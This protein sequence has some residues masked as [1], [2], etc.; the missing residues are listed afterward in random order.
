M[1]FIKNCIV[2]GGVKKPVNHHH[3][4]KSFS[5]LL[6]LLSFLLLSACGGGGDDP[7]L[8]SENTAISGFVIDGPISG[9]NVTLHRVNTDGTT[10]DQVAGPFTTDASGQW[11][12]TVP[13]NITGTL[14]VVA[15]GGQYTDDATGST[16]TLAADEVL[17]SWF[18]PANPADQGVVSPIT[19]SLWQ[20]AKQGMSTGDTLAV[21]VAAAE[22]LATDF[23][24]FDPTST[25]PNTSSTTAANLRYG[26]MLGG[27]SFLMDNR[28]ELQLEPFSSM[29]RFTLTR[30][31]M[32]DMA[33]GRLDG[34][35]IDGSRLEAPD[36]TLF[37][38]LSGND[39]SAFFTQVN[40]YTA[41]LQLPS[42]VVPNNYTV[43][44]SVYNCP[45]DGFFIYGQGTEEQNL[46]GYNN[47]FPN[48]TGFGNNVVKVA[49]RSVQV[50]RSTIT[51][52]QTG[53]EGYTDSYEVTF[54][55]PGLNLTSSNGSFLSGNV[56]RFV[57]QGYAST[58]TSTGDVRFLDVT[59]RGTY[60]W[61]GVRPDP[62]LAY[63]TSNGRL[64]FERGAG[65]TIPDNNFFNNN[66]HFASI[67]GSAEVGSGGPPIFEPAGEDH[68]DLFFVAA[69]VEGLSGTVVL[70]NNGGNTKSISTNSLHYFSAPI[71]DE[72]F[73][74]VSIV[75]QPDGQTCSLTSSAGQIAGS[76]ITS[77]G[78]SCTNNPE[79]TYSIGGSVS[80]LNGGSLVL[81]NNAGDDLPLSADGSF[82]FSTELLT[83]VGYG[84][85]ILSEPASQDCTVSNA[86]GT[87][88][89]ADITNV[90][91]SCV[92]VTTSYSI[93]GNVSGLIGTLVLRNNAGD[94]L[95]LSADGSFAFSTELLTGVGYSVTIFSSP[96]SQNCAV[97]SG[98]G[99][100]ST[101]DITTVSV[102]CAD[103]P[104]YTIGGSVTGLIGTLVLQ[105]NAGNNLTL[106]TN[107][108]F[109]FSTRLLSGVG[110][111]VTILS[112]PAAQN[113]SVTNPSGTVSNANVTS[114]QVVCESS[115]A[116]SN[117]L[118]SQ[119]ALIPSFLTGQISYSVSVTNAISSVTFTPIAV[120]GNAT[121]TVNGNAVVSGNASQTINLAEGSNTVTIQ[122]TADGATSNTSYTV[123]I[124]RDAPL[125]VDASLAALSLS[126]G[127]LTPAFSSGTFAYTASVGF[128]TTSI[129][130]T[131]TTNDAGATITVAGI[132]TV[133]GNA[134][135]AVNL[136]EG[137]NAIVVSVLAENGVTSQNY[138]VTVTRQ[139][140]SSFAQ[141]A[142]I[143]ASNTANG[144][145]FGS[146]I[147][148][149]GNTLVVAAKGEDSGTGSQTNNSAST[150]GAVYVFVRD[151]SGVWSQQA[152]L[153]A[154]NITLGDDFG[155]GLAISGDTLVVGAPTE[156]SNATGI[157][158][159]FRGDFNGAIN[160]PTGYDSGAVYVFTR[161]GAGSWSQQ[162]YIKGETSA[163]FDNFGSAV[164]LEGDTLVVGAEG[165]M[166]NNL[167]GNLSRG[168]AYV[169]I[170]DG[171]G[172]W[173]QQAHIKASN[174][175]GGFGTA[176]SLSGSTL[177]VA[178]WS[179]K[180]NATGI[181]GDDTDES[182]ISAG[183]VFVFTN[184]GSGNWT[185]QAY[186]KASNT[187]ANDFFGWSIA[188]SGETLAVGAFREGSNT[189]GINGDQNN[190]LAIDSGAVYVFTRT[191]G[192]WSQQAYIKASNTGDGDRFGNSI[193]LSAD[194]LAVGA[195][196]EGSNA[197]GIDGDEVNNSLGAGAGAVYLYERDGTG[198]WTKQA[199][200]K[201]SNT[202]RD[203]FGESVA[204]SG[205][206]IAVG[207]IGEDSRATGVNDP[208]QGD[209]T[210]FGGDS[211]AAYVFGPQ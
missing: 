25:V 145:Q 50:T 45:G 162:D 112:A 169:F 2:F 1:Y 60:N 127:S 187:D 71:A 77:V 124:I 83:G 136:I 29:N 23:W 135:A 73:Y 87:T 151:G 33:D 195:F 109:A 161:N 118:I 37:P 48:S 70:Q 185:Q 27:Y 22:Q 36:G 89:T 201:A 65:I 90:S 35:G 173:S 139:A 67:C 121:I 34:I 142:Y 86:S 182:L 155:H 131:P 186:I 76:N 164:A 41:F 154:S 175:G 54:D 39:L 198:S 132:S 122:V 148:M 93:G 51:H 147:A 183:A 81:Q 31:I 137:V 79:P 111:G 49:V 84:I 20:S 157:N 46:G 203:N 10:G 209:N 97:S 163:D 116:L 102:S 115:S 179:E 40:A 152:Y 140:A 82:T 210:T 106:T 59:Q 68:D 171:S 202:G 7:V 158:P 125:S 134:S 119:G 99:T 52:P 6:I 177:A 181:N 61:T 176:A 193:A 66:A 94:D 150:A 204:L 92:T 47:V 53:E 101:F 32:D 211:G 78:V 138:G 4:T 62:E 3:Q 130:L 105:N 96:T 120:D 56:L 114:V 156:D 58:G 165:E 128:S 113:C 107:D 44:P 17:H 117:L 167:S 178:S 19:D 166:G 192:V 194:T 12:G 30:L 74:N 16:I 172:N 197:I 184:D 98:S 174:A 63:V 103:L 146:T 141:E 15:V 205:S 180:S 11:S 43:Y 126:S 190:N 64:T 133:S 42:I 26:A 75:T 21:A 104:T 144:D 196:G 100:T 55:D 199:Y 38:I 85:T 95:L 188:L 153:K 168:A 159:V 69:S 91:V 88:S 108:A 9:S 170:R 110:Y 57:S 208:D 200:I 14:V 5:I 13:N 160:G 8:G 189:T 129:T 191:T 24:G 149:E 28:A 207:A 123:T 143:K 80:G 206:L 72:A 18:D